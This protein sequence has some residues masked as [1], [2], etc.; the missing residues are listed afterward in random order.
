MSIAMSP[1]LESGDRLSREE[2]H[3]RFCQHPEIKKAELVQGVVYVP[4]PTRFGVHGHQQKLLVL[5]LGAYELR[6]PSVRCGFD[7]TVFLAPDSEVMPDAFLFLLEPSVPGGARLR[8]DG[9]I[10]GAPQ[11]VAEVAASSASYDVHDKLQAY[12]RAG[13]QEY[14]V[15]RVLDQ[16]LDWFRLHDGAYDR[17]LPDE[18]GVIESAVFPGLRLYVAKLLAGDLASVLAELDPPTAD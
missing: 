5:W 17:I 8:D 4:S 14:L 1:P 18:S 6:H 12:A 2:F 9:Y 16:Q 15:W 3:S 7:A 13:V 10:D 11:L